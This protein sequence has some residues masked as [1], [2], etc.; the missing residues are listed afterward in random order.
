MECCSA[1]PPQHSK[2][3][4]C[5]LPVIHHTIQIRAEQSRERCREILVYLARLTSFVQLQHLWRVA[6]VLDCFFRLRLLLW[7]ILLL[8][9]LWLWQHSRSHFF[10]LNFASATARYI[11]LLCMLHP[12]SS[13]T[14]PLFFV[15]QYWYIVLTNCC[16]YH[17]LTRVHIVWYQVRSVSYD[18]QPVTKAETAPTAI[19]ISSQVANGPWS[20]QQSRLQY[21]NNNGILNI[22]PRPQTDLE[23]AR[24]GLKFESKI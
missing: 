22:M 9:L 12:R 7:P 23:T 15:Q 21:L 6:V 14:T 16:R 3:T 13:Q 2:C 5:V 4:R 10:C 20:C 18:T 11:Q 1:V 8:L 17:Q 24:T 19:D